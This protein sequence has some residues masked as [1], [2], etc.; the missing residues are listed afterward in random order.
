MW[1]LTQDRKALLKTENISV[2]GNGIYAITS[3]PMKDL[4]GQ[5]ENEVAIGTYKSN[6]QAMWVLGFIC[7]NLSKA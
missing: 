6:K 3:Q 4:N 7:R 1:I 2:F 5:E